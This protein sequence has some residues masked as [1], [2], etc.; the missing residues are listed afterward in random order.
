MQKDFDLLE[1]SGTIVGQK[2]EYVWRDGG[3][4]DR[5]CLENKSPGN[6]TESSNLSPSA[7]L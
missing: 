2:I 6:R 5:A 1:F 7:T 4:V 3:V